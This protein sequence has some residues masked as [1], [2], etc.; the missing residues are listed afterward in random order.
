MV[1]ARLSGLLPLCF[2]RRGEAAGDAGDELESDEAEV[3]S[4]GCSSSVSEP[5]SLSTG[6]RSGAVIGGAR[7]ASTA[8]SALAVPGTVRQHV[9][10]CTQ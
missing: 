1:D 8:G 6:G 2:L 3:V 5:L 9:T 7:V 10:L 4:D